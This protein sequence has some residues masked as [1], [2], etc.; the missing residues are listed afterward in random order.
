M[1]ERISA[2]FRGVKEKL[3]SMGIKFTQ[4][5][6][7]G[8]FVKIKNDFYKIH[9]IN[10]IER[11]VSLDKIHC[12]GIKLDYIPKKFI[13]LER[14]EMIKIPKGT[15]VTRDKEYIM[16]MRIAKVSHRKT[17]YFYDIIIDD[18]FFG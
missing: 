1:F 8:G 10:S 11:G 16:L 13:K 6:Y 7:L 17:N 18:D 15:S 2:F 4:V 5:L 9:E 14:E 3:G 12:V